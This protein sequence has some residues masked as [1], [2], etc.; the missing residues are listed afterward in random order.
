MSDKPSVRD[1]ASEGPAFPADLIERF[2]NA[3]NQGQSPVLEAYLP[4]DPAKRRAALAA[5]VRVD[6]QWR[7]RQGTGARLEKYLQRFPELADN[8]DA[9]AALLALENRLR[10]GEGPVAGAE[11]CRTPFLPFDPGMQP[12]MSSIEST[13]NPISSDDDN[14]AQTP[15]PAG[16]G[17]SSV[18]IR[19]PHCHNP[20]QITDERPEEVLCPGCGSP[21]RIR[22]ARLTDTTQGMRPLGK[23]QLLNRVG[24]GA[25]GAVWRARDSE[26]DRIVALKIPHAGLLSAPSELLRFHREA[27]AAAQLRH[28]G[29]VTVH[30]VEM[31]NGVPIIVAEFIEGVTLKSWLESRPLTFRDAATF[32][33]D[34]AEALDYAHGMGLV[35]RDL[36]PANIMIDFGPS[37]IAAAE[38]GKAPGTATRLGRPLI[39]DFGLALRDDSEITV[40]LDGQIIGTPAYMSPE[41]AAGKGHQADQ[42]SDVYSLGVILYEMLT[43]ELPFRGSREMIMHQVLREE[44]RP[45]RAL[46]QKIPRDL[47]TICLKAMAKA[48]VRRYATARD[49]GD[50]LRRFLRAEPIQARPITSLGRFQ[51]WCTRN[52]ALAVTGG[53]AAAALLAATTVA[54]LFALHQTQATERLKLETVRAD[55]ARRAAEQD[56][57]DAREA[58]RRA[59]TERDRATWMEELM[60]GRPEDSLTL[61]GATIRIPRSVGERMRF[62][63]IL[64][65]GQRK[66]E[67]RLKDLPD[68]RATMLDAI[69]GAYRGLGMYDEAETRL[70]ESLEIR[71]TLEGDKHNENLAA[72]YYNLAILYTTRARLDRSDFD[73]AQRSFEKALQL[74]GVQSVEDRRFEWNVLFGMA[75]LA[76]DQEDFA[77][78]R[79]LFEQCVEKHKHLPGCDHRDRIRARMGL[80]YASI[81]ETGYKTY[82]EGVPEL[83]EDALRQVVEEEKELKQAVALVQGAVFQLAV[84]DKL[85][86]L[87]PLNMLSKR[88]QTQ[89]F[90]DAALKLQ[91][92]YD[93]IASLHPEPHLYKPVVLYFLAGA[94]EKGGSIAEAEAAYAKCLEEARV[95]VGWEHMKVP[96]VAAN[97]ARLLTRLGKKEEANR[98]IAEVMRAQVSRFGEM[99]YFIANAM[100]TFA[101][102]Y[103]E[104]RDYP[105]QEQMAAK[106]LA[107]YQHTGG[108]K[109][110]LYQACNESLARALAATQQAKSRSTGS[111]Q[112]KR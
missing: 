20:I 49:F 106:A 80:V 110:R 70:K 34:V 95:T 84:T 40:T 88:V 112:D 104:L 48:S 56:R 100:M 10:L 91:K 81:E 76:I 15:E 31:L 36:K 5:L 29:I 7:L 30:E 3:W 37:K 107:I 28:P 77:R 66:S 62:V 83:L 78:S 87:G 46:N 19:C 96:L 90:V 67:I 43:G 6:M 1:A 92:A 72:S 64:E 21:F 9:V 109:R 55:L 103:E 54:I 33:A 98:L 75:W 74:R 24:I 39:M 26:L 2:E 97:R 50:D 94:L 93:L 89:G 85:P 25:F 8:P 79:A 42:R 101:D 68:I 65:R 45:P 58:Q 16:S 53:L 57:N 22:E 82:G 73:N 111:G 60:V 23:F 4:S 102:L 71:Q 99:H 69:G 17:G 27:R 108:A 86:T 105:A 52:P 14:S 44:P 35:H 51:R 18:H 41:Q 63:D 13:A 11:Q 47:E 32:M 61:E 59:E 38:P 12:L